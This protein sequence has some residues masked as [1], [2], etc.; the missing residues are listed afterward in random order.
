M[1][2]QWGAVVFAVI[3]AVLWLKSAM[4][5]TPSSFPI[6]VI[7]PDSFSRP[8]GEPLSGT[9]VGH[10]HSPALNDLGEA[11]RCQSKWSAHAAL[12]RLPL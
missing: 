10:G 11:L 5:K 8:L 2:V 12:L 1:I 6:N 3:A 4:I 7:R 9:N